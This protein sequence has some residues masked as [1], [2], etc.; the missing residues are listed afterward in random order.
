M[1]FT[2]ASNLKIEIWS[3]I[4]CPFCYIAKRHFEEALAQFPHKDKV[5]VEW[6]SFQL[7]PNVPED[8]HGES[9]IDSFVREKG[10]STQQAEGLFTNVV[11]MAKQSGLDFHMEKV[12]VA[13][14]INAH[15]LSHLAKTQGNQTQNDIEELLFKAYFTEGRNVNDKNTLTEIGLSVG[16][17]KDELKNLFNSHDFADKVSYDIQEAG[18]FGITSVPYFVLNRKY[19]ISG[20]QPSSAFLDI[21]NQAYNN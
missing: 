15:R 7:N 18:V 14:T 5:V 9:L 12:V 17:G 16:L 6:K 21:L 20:A 1:S 2:L 3:D 11:N 8:T 13:N 4:A 10:M 19:A